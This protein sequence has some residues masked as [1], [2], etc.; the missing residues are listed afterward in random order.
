[1]NIVALENGSVTPIYELANAR[2][3][4]YLITT[5][6][7]YEIAKPD[8]WVG[9]E[10][11]FKRDLQWHGFLFE[12][13]DN[14][15]IKL[16][17]GEGKEIV[18]AQ[19]ATFGQ[20]AY[21]I[22]REMVEVG[23]EDAIQWEGRLDFNK[24]KYG[25]NTI[26]VG[27]Q[28]SNVE[29]LV[30]NR[31]DSKVNLN[32]LTSVDGTDI[33]T[34]QPEHKAMAFHSKSL[35]LTYL[36]EKKNIDVVDWTEILGSHTNFFIQFNTLSPQ[37]NDIEL[38]YP[39]ALSVSSAHPITNKYYIIKPSYSGNYAFDISTQFQFKAQHI[40]KN[41]L[42]SSYF[43]TWG[44]ALKL[45]IGTN[46]TTLQEIAFNPSTNSEEVDYTFNWTYTGSHFVLAN[47]P[48][49]IF[50]EFIV[51]PNNSNYKGI[52]AYLKNI[53]TTIEINAT[54]NS[55]S[56]LGYAFETKDTMDFVLSSISNNEIAIESDFY[57]SVC[58]Q[59]KVLT[60]GLLLRYV[61][62]ITEPMV[63]IPTMTT[64][65]RDLME[66]LR[67]IDGIGFGY[68]YQG[69]NT[70]IRV[71]PL[72][73]FY[74][75]VEIISLDEE[76]DLDTY[77]EEVAADL[78]YSNINV[79]YTKYPKEDTYGLDE[80]NTEINYKTPIKF[81]DNTYDIRSPYIGSGYIIERQRRNPITDDSKL[82]TDYDDDNFVICVENGTTFTLNDIEVNFRQPYLFETM[83]E[84]IGGGIIINV[85]V[86]VDPGNSFIYD[87]ANLLTAGMIVTISG[88]TYNNGNF[89]VVRIVFIEAF[90]S[91]L[92]EV[93]ES[94]VEEYPVICDVAVI[95]IGYV[96]ETDTS[97]TVAN[98]VD[99][100]TAYNLRI[101]PSYNLLNHGKWINSGLKYKGG[102]EKL[103]SKKA[104]QNKDFSI[105]R[106]VGESCIRN[107]VNRATYVAKNDI[108]LSNFVER[109]KIFS[110]ERIVVSA[111]LQPEQ[112]KYIVN[113]HRGLIAGKE[114]GFITIKNPKGEEIE[115]WLE[116]I[117][118]LENGQTMKV[119]FSF[120]KKKT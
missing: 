104:V 94:V 114:Y 100:A 5:T 26:E 82:S 73:Y 53:S 43:D 76:L 119:E 16:H 106:E 21:V 109:E 47:Q 48:I 3:T 2:R 38:S 40:R 75:D 90:N 87:Q 41:F 49:Y 4:Y 18:E 7:S 108:I 29:S 102:S 27:I 39:Y 37:K 66:T 42:S 74:Q 105:S 15:V 107:D 117:T 91:Y 103:L 69:A 116:R 110:P 80:F 17:E 55:E 24:F 98:I 95:S 25:N 45:V 70:V 58:G 33:S 112:I 77:S 88:T 56:S 61:N 120:I 93:L 63:V 81:H 65:F 71:E 12:G 97:F 20:D 83:E 50:A 46:E 111:Y 13:A 115:C 59:K 84:D 89:T 60:S 99:S 19:Y 54:T 23:I 28:R 9:L 32:D 11:T 30:Q 34:L 6:D 62:H 113:C 64:T 10:K 86:P 1:M 31:W 36:N 44:M 51:E 14:T 8:G 79:G 57:T 78:I 52:N 67:S 96:S 22:I 118:E 92:V 68:E 101:C 72:E 85:T 35:L